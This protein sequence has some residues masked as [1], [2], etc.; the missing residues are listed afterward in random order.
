MNQNNN[1]NNINNNGDASRV[2]LV[3]DDGNLR[4]ENVFKN[5][6]SKIGAHLDDGYSSMYQNNSLL[7]GIDA[8]PSN[9]LIE[10]EKKDDESSDEELAFRERLPA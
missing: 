3:N 10:E 4:A 7:N 8:Q 1:N 2:I 5:E 6:V 9:L